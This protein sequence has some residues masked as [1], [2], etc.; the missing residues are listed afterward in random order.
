M[1]ILEIL[2]EIEIEYTGNKVGDKSVPKD[3]LLN[4][5]NSNSFNVFCY[6]IIR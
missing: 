1:L 2:L 6:Y 4:V 5:M 3:I